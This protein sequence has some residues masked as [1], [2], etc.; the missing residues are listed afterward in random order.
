MEEEMVPMWV[1]DQGK[2]QNTK[3]SEGQVARGAE[4]NNAKIVVAIVQ[5]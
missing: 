3:R 2:R 5:K 4:K 1:I